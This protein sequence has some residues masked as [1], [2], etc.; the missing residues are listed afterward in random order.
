MLR[1]R[2]SEMNTVLFQSNFMSEG[3]KKHSYI[4]IEFSNWGFIL[5]KL[6]PPFGILCMNGMIIL[7]IE[8]YIY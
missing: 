1:E 2:E 3:K 6:N 5:L 8:H 7:K 4:L